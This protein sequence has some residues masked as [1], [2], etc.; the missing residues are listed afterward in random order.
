MNLALSIRFGRAANTNPWEATTLEWAATAT[1]PRA[2]GNFERPVRV[3]RDPYD[4]SVPGA[5]TGFL[6]QNVE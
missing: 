4:Y 6:P 1:P 3:F 2:H 5:T